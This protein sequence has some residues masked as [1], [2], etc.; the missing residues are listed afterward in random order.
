MRVCVCHNWVRHAVCYER[1]EHTCFHLWASRSER[2][3][4]DDD[5]DGDDEDQSSLLIQCAKKAGVDGV[6]IVAGG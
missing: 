5:G 1:H 4:A 3:D 2:V 6:M